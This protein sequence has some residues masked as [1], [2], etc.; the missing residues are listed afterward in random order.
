MAVTKMQ[1]AQKKYPSS[2]DLKAVTI[3]TEMLILLK[4]FYKAF[5]VWCESRNPI[6]LYGIQVL[7]QSSVGVYAFWMSRS[8]QMSFSSFLEI[9]LE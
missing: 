5:Q 8:Y 3:L 6:G 1:D 7:L 4:S 9:V 2:L